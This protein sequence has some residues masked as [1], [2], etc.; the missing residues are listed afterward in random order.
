MSRIE[1]FQTLPVELWVIVV[2]YYRRNVKQL[3]RLRATCKALRQAVSVMPARLASRGAKLRMNCPVTIAQA[4]MLPSMW[5]NIT[6]IRL[7]WFHL[8]HNTAPVYTALQHVAVM[9]SI[10]PTLSP[11]TVNMRNDRSGFWTA[12]L[13]TSFDLQRCKSLE[14]FWVNM[15]DDVI[16]ACSR[17]SPTTLIIEPILQQ[18]LSSN[19]NKLVACC[20]SDVQTLQLRRASQP[21]LEAAKSCKLL[22][23]LVIDEAEPGVHLEHLLSTR[24]HRLT[25]SRFGDINSCAFFDEFDGVVGT[26]SDTLRHL[27][28]SDKWFTFPIIDHTLDNSVIAGFRN[29]VTLRL[30]GVTMWNNDF[31]ESMAACVTQLEA[32]WYTP[33]FRRDGPDWRT[34]NTKAAQALGHMPRL[35]GLVLPSTVLFERSE[36]AEALMTNSLQVIA[37]DGH[38]GPYHQAIAF[39]GAFP[40]DSA[41]WKA[42][43]VGRN[44]RRPLKFPNDFT[45]RLSS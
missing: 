34:L 19:A 12:S 16:A 41:L 22:T 42:M 10:T 21:I 26:K 20:G 38:N 9:E 4:K 17:M 15:S 5:A 44:L 8:S 37:A 35:H 23:T 32:L 6:D 3:C 18:W 29:L 2:S 30:S 14:L 31:L 28:A 33:I 36:Q 25:L 7:D 43:S 1:V 40:Y 39:T 45:R 27:D 13:L 11:L 24:L